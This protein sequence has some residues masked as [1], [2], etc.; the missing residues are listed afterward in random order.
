MQYENIILKGASGTTYTFECYSPETTFNKVGAVYAFL[1]RQPS[2]LTGPIPLY[3]GIAQDFATRFSGHERWQEAMTQG[4]NCVAGLVNA[5]ALYRESVEKDIIKAYNPV[6]NLVYNALA[7]QSV[8][9]K[10]RRAKAGPAAN[11]LAQRRG[12]L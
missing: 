4:A 11:I 6:M 9:D 7:R 3:V 12:I 1:N 10:L 2:I 8:E 5:S